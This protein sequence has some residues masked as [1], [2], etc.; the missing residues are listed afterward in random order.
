MDLPGAGLALLVVVGGGSRV[1]LRPLAIYMLSTVPEA[2]Y[3][4]HVFENGTT[5]AVPP[6]ARDVPKRELTP[7]NNK[8]LPEALG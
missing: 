1:A 8:T 6:R 5:L 7:P 2:R 4:Y 3:L